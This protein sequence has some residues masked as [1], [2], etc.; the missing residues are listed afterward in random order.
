MRKESEFKE[1]LEGR[2]ASGSNLTR[3]V[4]RA[5]YD[6]CYFGEESID[7]SK[8]VIE[9]GEACSMYPEIAEHEDDMVASGLGANSDIPPGEDAEPIVDESAEVTEDQ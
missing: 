9:G 6:Y 5:V 4:Y 7:P 8:P 2:I 1:W 3:D